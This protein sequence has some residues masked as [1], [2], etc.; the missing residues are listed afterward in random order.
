MAKPNY[1]TARWIY[2]VVDAESGEVLLENRPDEMIYTGSTAKNFTVGS[3]YETLGP[4]TTLTTPIYATAPVADGVV[5]GDVVLVASGD[6]VLGGRGGIEG[7]VEHTFYQDT[8]D[9][10]YANIAPNARPTS[11]V[12][13]PLAGLNDLAQQVKASGV[14]RIDGDVLIDTRLF[15]TYSGGDGGVTPIFVNDNLLDVTVTAGSPATIVVS[16]Q[17]SAY[18]VVSQVDTVAADEDSSLSVEPDPTDPTKLIVSGSIAEGKSQLTTYQV[19]DPAD[20]ARVLLIEALGRAG[21]SVG[22]PPNRPNNEGALPAPAAFTDDRKLASLQSP[23]LSAMGA[24]ILETSYNAGANDFLC[25]LAVERGSTDCAAGLETIYD[26]AGKAGLDTTAVFLTDGQ[27]GD[28]ASTTP[29]Q[30]TKWVQWAKAQPWGQ[31]FFDGQPVLGES[32]SLAPYGGDSP[33]KGKVAAKAG[34]GVALNPVNGRL[35]S[36]VQSLAGYITLDDGTLLAFDLAMGGATFDELYDGLVQAG[37]D[38]AGVAAA[39]QEGLGS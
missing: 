16:P 33:A 3:V 6:F 1:S 35:L 13:D 28:P 34:T 26:L 4:E 8:V 25:L 12:G 31:A 17:T 10:V 5:P 39:F 7:K 9:H 27:G 24:M 18:S 21:V 20:W 19:P 22:A 15:E 11:D 32:G 38:L 14:N 29:R 30:M 2:Y 36:N 37:G 23:P